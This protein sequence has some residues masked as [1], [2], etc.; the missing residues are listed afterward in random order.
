M[1]SIRQRVL[2]GI[3]LGLLFSLS[4]CSSPTQTAQSDA[5]LKLNIGA[6]PSF[7]NPVLMTDSASSSVVGLVFDGLFKRN[8]DLDMEKELVKSYSVS[9]DGLTYTFR[10]RKGV[11][12]HDGHPFT[13]EDVNYTFDVLLDPK[14]NT[15]RRGHFI[16]NGNPIIFKVIDTHTIQATLPQPFAPFIATLDMGIL[17]KHLLEGKDINTAD[18]NRHPIGTGPFIFKDWKSGQFVTLK[19]N[20]HYFKGAPKLDGILMKII[21]DPN[22]A[23]MALQ[24]NELDAAGIPAKDVPKI[25]KIS[26]LDIYKY[27]RLNYSYICTLNK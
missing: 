1:N 21:P 5:I 9:K 4:A 3:F 8:E 10:L 6:N 7:L 26:Y 12:W 27:S 20:P 13:A 22:T 18:F 2:G 14:T 23:L 16:I 15:V 19:K 25:E 24:K 17:P 11:K